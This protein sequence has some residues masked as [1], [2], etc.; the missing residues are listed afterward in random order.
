MFWPPT[1]GDS[2][3]QTERWN[4]TGVTA[5]NSD[6]GCLYPKITDTALELYKDRELGASD[7]V[8]QVSGGHGASGAWAKKTLTEANTSGIAG[9]LGFRYIAADSGL[10]VYPLLT[11]DTELDAMYIGATSIYPKNG[12]A[13]FFTQHRRTR[14]EFVNLM[15][16]RHPPAPAAL[17]S[18][19]GTRRGDTS[20]MWVVNSTGDYEIKKLQNVVAWRTW[21]VHFVMAMIAR[22]PNRSL[23][24]D[25]QLRAITDADEAAKNAWAEI[26]PLVDFDQDMDADVEIPRYRVYRG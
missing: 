7:L 21:A 1:R 3:N 22:Q 15:Q 10:E 16:Q 2:H 9:S 5:A 6:R 23:D 12:A 18:L 14:E 24:E 4:I 13:T 26:R 19:A 8:A 25:T 20:D 17:R 11:T